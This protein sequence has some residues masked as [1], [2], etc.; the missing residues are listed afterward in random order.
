MYRYLY[1]IIQYCI[2]TVSSPRQNILIIFYVKT[3]IVYRYLYLIIQ[4]CRRTVSSPRQNI[5]IY[6][7]I[8]NR[9]S[10]QIFISNNTILHKN[11]VFSQTEHPYNFLC[12]NRHS[13]QIFI[14]NNTILQK[15]SVFSQTEHPYKFFLSK[16]D[17]VYRYLYLITQCCR[18]TVSSPRLDVLIVPTIMNNITHSLLS[19]KISLHRLLS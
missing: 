14:S 7:F 19:T 6:F 16:T 3:D 13:V 8:K 12:Q 1:L 4:F 9:H 2:R 18:R 5:L 15:N 10:V 17:I 11:S